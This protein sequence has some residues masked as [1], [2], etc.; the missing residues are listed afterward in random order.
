MLSK[1][2]HQ[3]RISDTRVAV[4]P[5]RRDQPEMRM[6][7]EEQF[8][9]LQVESE[10]RAKQSYHEGYSKGY[11]DGSAKG[12]LEAQSVAAR[13]NKAILDID[14]QRGELLR[15]AEAECAELALRIARKIIDEHVRIDTNI[16]ISSFKKA[17]SLLLDK[18]KLLVRVAPDQ[19]ATIKSQ[20]DTLYAMDD[21][22]EHIDIEADPR[23]GAGG[24][25]VE[26]E[27]G[28]VDARIES[29][30]QIISQAI[31]EAMS[32]ARE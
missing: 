26:T 16:L 14:R 18:S 27:A 4:G 9:R 30:F 7:P 6:V 24:C 25:V 21:N 23:V 19:H 8:L 20:L 28:N 2:L 10:S 1:V 3:A 12:R 22:I 32:E 31:S 5:L 29:Q 17:V 11:E 13:L 15:T